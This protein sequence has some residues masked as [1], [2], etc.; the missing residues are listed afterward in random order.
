MATTR[1]DT[2]IHALQGGP[3][4]LGAEKGIKSIE[5]WEEYLSKHE[6]E[7]VKAVVADLG[8]L[9]K[10]LHAGEPDSAAIQKLLQ[11]LGKDTVKVAGEDTS[12]SAAKIKE[13]GET[14]SKA[15]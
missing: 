8:K 6:H 3:E 13:L 10:L 1:F 9:K 12:A 14:L 4:Q 11:K 7:G 5:S 15:Q 2:T